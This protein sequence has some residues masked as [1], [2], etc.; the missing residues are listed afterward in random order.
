MAKQRTYVSD[1]ISTNFPT[2]SRYEIDQ[3]L[4][5]RRFSAEDIDAAWHS[6]LHPPKKT[7]SSIV[8]EH[9]KSSIA[10]LAILGLIIWVTLATTVFYMDPNR[11]LFDNVPDYPNAAK[12]TL[13]PATRTSIR[14]LYGG[15][16]FKVF[17]SADSEDQILQYYIQYTDKNRYEHNNY[18]YKGS[19]SWYGAFNHP[20]ISYTSL[21]IFSNA[22]KN[23]PNNALLSQEA[24]HGNIIVLIKSYYLGCC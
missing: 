19:N 1:Y 13:D 5:A 20:E 6:I 11:I 22:R 23:V 3:E 8:I 12:L 15:L 24:A 10:V 4:L 17:V 14:S 7:I 2:R 16:D 18:N 21:V 9:K